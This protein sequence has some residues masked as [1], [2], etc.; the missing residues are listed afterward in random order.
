MFAESLLETSW[1]QRTC[2]SW[3]TLTSFGLQALVIGLLLVLPLRKTVGLPSVRVLPTP[4]SWGAPPPAAPAARHQNVTTIV[5]NNLADNV[6][7][8]P[9]EV[10][11]HVVQIEE[12]VA[13]PQISFIIV[14]GEFRA[15]RAMVQGSESGDRSVIPRV[16]PL[17]YQ[18]LPPPSAH[19]VL[20]ACSREA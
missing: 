6:L 18:F 14:L 16:I 15:E 9:R 1:G 11:N 13:P 7:I 5:Q 10:P 3:T 19:S 17:H 8:A 20:R 4:V 12:V 2:R